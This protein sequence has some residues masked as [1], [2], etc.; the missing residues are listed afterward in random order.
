[1]TH[2]PPCPDENVLAAML[3]GDL[4]TADIEG[5]H[6]HVDHCA[7]C[8]ALMVELG[9]S[10][11][12]TQAPSQP[13][14]PASSQRNTYARGSSVARYEIRD[15]LGSGGMGL[16]YLAFDAELDRQ[17]ALKVLH[18]S[19]EH[20]GRRILREA[21]AMA[22]VSHPHVVQ[23][24]EVGEYEGGS[25]VAMELVTGTTL[26]RW[27][28]G[29]SWSERLTACVLAGEGLAAAH[30]AELVHRDFKPANVLCGD[31]GQI[32][33]TDFGLAASERVWRTES[34]LTS[35][36]QTPGSTGSV[37]G[38]MGG[39]PGYM[40]PEQQSGERTDARADQFSF[41]VTAWEILFGERPTLP[42]PHKSAVTSGG[43]HRVDRARVIEALRRGLQPDPS[44]RWPS[45]SALLAKL[46]HEPRRRKRDWA[47]GLASAAAVGS[48]TF[49]ASQWSS[50]PVPCLNAGVAAM[51][52]L[53][54]ESDRA[55]VHD[56]LLAGGPQFERTS[57]LVQLRMDEFTDAWIGMSREACEAAV[58]EHTQ[59][60]TLLDLRTA[61]LARAADSA[62]ATLDVLR[63]ANADARSNAHVLVGNL[64]RL[65]P[66]ADVQGLQARTPPP[67]APDVARAVTALG[68]RVEAA[69]LQRLS[70]R[71]GPAAA[72]LDTLAGEVEATDYEPLIARFELERAWSLYAKGDFFGARDLAQTGLHRAWRS[73]QWG[74]A[75]DLSQLLGAVGSTLASPQAA[76][77]HAQTA[78]ALADRPRSDPRRRGAAHRSMAEALLLTGDLDRA[79]QHSRQ[80][81]EILGEAIG[82]ESPAAGNAHHDLAVTLHFLGRHQEAEAEH[83][84]ALEILTGVFGPAHPEVARCEDDLGQLYVDMN[85]YAEA[86]VL[87]RSAVRTQTDALGAS[88]PAT[89]RAML[90][91]ANSLVR[92]DDTDAAIEIYRKA[93]DVLSETIG[94]D[95]A[96]TAAVRA[97]HAIA[98]IIQGDTERGLAQLRRSVADQ[99]VRLGAEHPR[100]AAMRN[101]LAVEL[102]EAGLTDDAIAELQ[103]V[104]AIRERIIGRLHP[105]TL[106]ALRDLANTQL[107]AEYN[108]E[109]RANY[110]DL[111]ARL[112]LTDEP[113]PRLRSDM[114]YSLGLLARRAG[115]LEEARRWLEPALELRRSNGAEPGLVGHVEFVL[116]RVWSELGERERAREMA[117]AAEA[118]Y[119]SA[120]PR[121]DGLRNSVVEWLATH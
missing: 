59:S 23:V 6:A 21:R 37:T 45:M 117:R 73:E 44:D 31:D 116:A 84:R 17:V 77:L 108:D 85:R 26:D 105:E 29:R 100:V 63:E 34:T 60:T 15:L 88:H 103:G 94:P 51:D 40:A 74:L 8:R 57:T 67:D 38:I 86:E 22:R 47:I 99:E 87:H 9:H 119:L 68:E 7:A 16:V 3:E 106:E 28:R 97:S 93:L 90:G 101:S 49:G 19:T 55:Q 102:M 54:S 81:L 96:D 118:S 114:L 107:G 104:I 112:A 98:L 58:V 76:L 35:T 79:E 92:R 11:E 46:H 25:Y 13:S 41:C 14:A 27:A 70:G 30:A 4:A 32:K 39:T 53:W 78:L 95:H 65:E 5:L 1:M 64:P 71:S 33:V 115:D 12:H 10:L 42:A 110:L 111:R 121:R 61:C 120:G 2:D 20:S 24:H 62:R 80:G 75:G 18:T 48:L 113:L 69:T 66:C 36:I 83:L 82:P 109:A 91:L 56:A 43:G 89:G 52:D 72:I 50:A